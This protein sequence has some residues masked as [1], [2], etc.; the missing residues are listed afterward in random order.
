[1]FVVLHVLQSIIG[2]LDSVRA[3]RSGARIPVGTRRSV[4]VQTGLKAYS[5]S[6]TMGTGSFPGAKWLGRGTDHPTPSAGLRMGWNYTSAS[7][8]C[9]LRHI[10]A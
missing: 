2:G 6:C 5:A 9:L 8:L 3:G 4:P 1:M 10:M 7:Q